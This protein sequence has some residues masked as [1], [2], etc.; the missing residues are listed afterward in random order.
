MMA[1]LFAEVNVLLSALS[2]VRGIIIQNFKEPG[3]TFPN[4]IFLFKKKVKK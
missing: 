2:N 3:M 4:L 1:S